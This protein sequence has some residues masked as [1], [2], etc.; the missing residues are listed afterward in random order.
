[1]M[2]QIEISFELDAFET[3]IRFC[4]AIKDSRDNDFIKAFSL[5]QLTWKTSKTSPYFVFNGLKEMMV[6]K[7]KVKPMRAVS[8]MCW[9]Y[10]V[11][12]SIGKYS[13]KVIREKEPYKPSIH[14]VWGVN[15]LSFRKI[16]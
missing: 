9:F 6:G 14:G 11:K 15:P 16:E 13:C 5:C 10:E 3:V 2:E 8:E 1:M 4:D 12:T 7:I